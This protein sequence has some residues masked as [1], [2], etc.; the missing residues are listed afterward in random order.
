MVLCLVVRLDKPGRP[1]A[2]ESYE[3]ETSRVG[4][5]ELRRYVELASCLGVR[6]LRR[7]VFMGFTQRSVFDGSS[8]C[9]ECMYV[10]IYLHVAP[11]AGDFRQIDTPAAYAFTK[12]V[13]EVIDPHMLGSSGVTT[14]VGL[15]MNELAR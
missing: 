10:C 3:A 6:S 9:R 8:D 11:Q 5:R 14:D 7:T 4:A 1:G 13:Q 15:S 12:A 2:L